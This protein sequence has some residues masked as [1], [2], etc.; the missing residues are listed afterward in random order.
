VDGEYSEEVPNRASSRTV[1]E[2]FN[3]DSARGG[4]ERKRP[5][6]DE[7]THD[8]IQL[9]TQ[10][11]DEQQS[12]PTMSTLGRICKHVIL[13]RAHERTRLRPV[14]VRA[15]R[16]ARCRG[17]GRHACRSRS[18][19]LTCTPGPAAPPCMQV[20]IK[21]IHVYAGSSGTAARN[22]VSSQE[23]LNRLCAEWSA[24]RAV[25]SSLR[26]DGEGNGGGCGALARGYPPSHTSIKLEATNV[27]IGLALHGNGISHHDVRALMHGPPAPPLEEVRARPAM[28]AHDACDAAMRAAMHARCYRSQRCVL[29]H[30]C[31]RCTAPMA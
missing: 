2:V 20:A 23:R 12:A 6:L 21:W 19:G 24:L 30:A 8:L 9:C 25:R 11:S 13:P 17:V 22:G 7:L 10:P 26:A 31:W 4:A 18:N 1:R 28:H 29:L 14:S 15:Q 27:V 16:V 5:T 3:L